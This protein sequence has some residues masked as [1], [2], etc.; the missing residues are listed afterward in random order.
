MRF[1]GKYLL[2]DRISKT[3]LKSSYKIFGWPIS[4]QS[5]DIDILE[6]AMIPVAVYSDN[7]WHI[8]FRIY[9]G[10]D[11]FQVKENNEYSM[12]SYERLMTDSAHFKKTEKK[13]REIAK[14]LSVP[15]SIHWWSESFLRNNLEELNCREFLKNIEVPAKD[16]GELDLSTV[17][18]VFDITVSKNIVELDSPFVF[19]EY[20]KKYRIGV[21]MQQI[22]F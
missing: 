17:K 19:P 8:F 10:K 18:S 4:S 5:L 16:E 3:I 2:I 1:C 20:M 12:N 22:L 21:L 9:G 6:I 15:V 11:F 14:W 13:M 7:L